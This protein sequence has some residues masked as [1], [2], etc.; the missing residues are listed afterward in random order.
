MKGFN[1]VDVGGQQNERRKW[2][3]CFADVSILI[4]VASLSDYD[5]NCYEDSKKNRMLESLEV[6]ESTIN[7]NFFF[8]K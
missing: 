6:F 4:Y 7:G 8:L 2:K 1:L 5:Q 3:K